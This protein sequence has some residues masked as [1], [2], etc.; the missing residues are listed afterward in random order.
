MLTVTVWFHGMHEGDGHH[1]DMVR[2]HITYDDVSIFTTLDDLLYITHIDKRTTIIP[3][4][5]IFKVQSR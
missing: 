4:R 3:W 5:N 2:D 1:A